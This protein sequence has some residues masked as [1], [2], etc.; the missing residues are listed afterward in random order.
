MLQILINAL[1]CM[2]NQDLIAISKE[3]MSMNIAGAEDF[4]NSSTS[5]WK[6]QICLTKL[7]LQKP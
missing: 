3:Y 1:Q 2:T 6:I 5:S 4:N 7:R